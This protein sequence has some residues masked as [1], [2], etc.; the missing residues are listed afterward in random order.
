MLDGALI[1]RARA[2]QL[3]TEA[4]LIVKKSVTRD[5]DILVVA[6]PHSLSGKA[7]KAREY[8]IPAIVSVAN[9]TQL[10]DGAWV[11]LDGYR[12]EIVIQE[13]GGSL[14]T[15]DLHRSEN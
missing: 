2:E 9:A 4:G 13:N 15:A 11:S 14:P 3:A 6:D 8:G 10:L 7:R 1:S 5:L 12:G